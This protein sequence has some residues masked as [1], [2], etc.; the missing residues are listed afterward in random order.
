MTIS[1]PRPAKTTSGALAKKIRVNNEIE[2]GPRQI[3]AGPF[4]FQ[5]FSIE[6]GIFE[7]FYSLPW[8][9]AHSSISSLRRS[10]RAS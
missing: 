7:F 1:G 2:M 8:P 3:E 6:I 5:T 4:Q 9:G 10:S